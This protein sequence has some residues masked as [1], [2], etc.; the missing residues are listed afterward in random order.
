MAYGLA[1]RSSRRLV[2]LL[3]L[4]IALVVPVGAVPSSAGPDD[5]RTY[6]IDGVTTS[7]QRSAIASTGAGIE[8]VGP[9]YVVVRA[10]ES[11]ASAI[12]AKGLQPNLVA[13]TDD[14]PPADSD[15]NNYAEMVADINAVA[16][17][18]PDLVQTFSIGQSYQ[19]R[20]MVVAKIS[21][22]VADDEAEPEVVYD[23]LH[24]AREHLTVEM[25]L[26][27]LHWYADGYASDTRI[28]NIVDSREIFIVFSVNPDGGEYDVATGS[29]R[30]WRK[31]RQPND[32]TSAVGT[33]L[34]RNYG[35]RWGCC[36]G[37]SGQP[38]SETYRGA[39]PF[40]A[41]ETAAYRDFVNSRVVNGVQ[42]VRANISYHTY[43]EL[44]L[45]PYGY[46]RKDV[47]R[48]MTVDDHDVFVEM[49][50][51]MAQSTCLTGFGCYTPEQASD[52]Y[53]TDG[54]SDDWLYGVHRIFTFTFEMYPKGNPGFYPPD[55]VIPTQTERNKESVLYLAENADCV[56][57]TTG[58]QAAYCPVVSSFTPRRGAAGTPV[59]IRGSGF[60]GAVGVAFD[61]VA[62]AS[63]TVVSD[64]EITTV[65]P[66]GAR[67]GKVTVDRERG[68]G[69]SAVAF[70]VP[71]SLGAF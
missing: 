43:S 25:S 14:F 57:R 24:H 9:D 15:Y 69:T 5:V 1:M 62:A 54:T 27:I 39:F 36:G 47:P 22:N 59:T 38:S 46:T 48:D 56:F 26:A 8:L 45:W 17:E 33:D 2:V 11:E 16:A 66:A 28:R 20:E 61:G 32:G 63:F 70:K 55:E 6:R 51:T 10:L 3:G 49:G 21:D 71:A 4:V 30:F 68:T 64:T 29:Y 7:Q 67:T 65:V 18:H 41:P 35:Y 42:Q 34:N 58:T 37:S 31:N 60:T 40:S 12:R 44:V 23:A 53:I 19:G 52:L 50:T 13:G